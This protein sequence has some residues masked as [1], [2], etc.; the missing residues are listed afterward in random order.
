MPQKSKKS[1]SKR[2]TLK[3]KYKVIKKVKE[4][5]RKK[6]KEL[7]KSGKKPKAP[8]DPGVPSQWPFKAELMKE[9]EW[10]KQR[11]LA[12]EK[13]KKEQK[14]EAKLL[15]RSQA[16]AAGDEEM[17]EPQSMGDVQQQAARKQYEFQANKK[18]RLS[19]AVGSADRD[20]SRRAFYKEF[21]KVVEAAD[22]IIE[23]LDARD[24]LSCRCIDVERYIRRS[25]PDKKIILLLNK[26]DLVPRE[27]AEQWLKY[28]REELPAVAFKCSTQKQATNLGQKRM[29]GKARAVASAAATERAFQGS[30]C[31]GAETLLQLLKNY[32]R[33]LNIKTAITVGI[34]GLPNVGKSSLINSLKRTRVAPVG[35]TPGV[36][37]SVQEVHLDKNVKLLDSPGIV[38]SQLDKDSAASQALRNCVKVERLE[39]PVL[40]VT[41]IVKRCPAKQLMMTYKIPAFKGADEF[42]QLIASA[43]GKL[44]KGGSVDV[45]AA[46]RI[47]L[48]DWN[49]GRIA[50]YTLPPV[51]ENEAE[52][53]AA[54]VGSWGQE[55]NADE[56]FSNERSTVIAGLPSLEDARGSYFQTDAAG[57]LALDLEAMEQA[58]G[59]ERRNDSEASGSEEETDGED[60]SLDAMIE[61]TKR[62]Q[63]K[64]APTG[65]A[66]TEALY[67]EEGQFNPHKARADKKRAKKNKELGDPDAFDF[68]EAF[69]EEEEAPMD[70]QTGAGTGEE[71]DADSDAGADVEGDN[72]GDGEE[73]SAGEELS[74]G[75]G[76]EGSDLEDLPSDVE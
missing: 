26:I 5:H 21:Q 40:P 52:G 37:K 36:T 61:S 38:F 15:K 4:H 47:V 53:E 20:G 19:E 33:N 22:V 34:V 3:N 67:S 69:G 66:Q 1:K 18:A 59:D 57:A 51:R 41:E 54:V 73:G 46:A 74:E 49:D 13:Q 62:K 39:D 64:A 43:R 56:V 8:K 27:V 7:R 23:V 11:I 63:Q 6:A 31:L 48:Q 60:T 25:S 68:D 45:A 65:K 70:G 2:Q 55:F 72:D 28:L 14:K 76:M 75:E 44:K 50:Y 35:N 17:A 24:P 12:K 71:D 32:A 42:L 29:P 10:E 9:L 16:D 58:S 30:E